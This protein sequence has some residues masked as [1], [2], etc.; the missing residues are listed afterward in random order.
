M[1]ISR[2]M[3]FVKLIFFYFM[4]M[5]QALTQINFE[6]HFLLD[7]DTCLNCMLYSKVER[8]IILF[9]PTA[10]IKELDFEKR[11]KEL[12]SSLKDIN[13]N[14]TLIQF[15]Y[16]KQNLKSDA[17]GL[18]YI[19]KSGDS[20]AINYFKCFIS[21]IDTNI[22]TRAKSKMPLNFEIKK[23]FRDNDLFEIHMRDTSV[24]ID[25]MNKLS[26]Y[27]EFIVESINPKYSDKERIEMLCKITNNLITRIEESEMKIEDL[28]AHIDKLNL[29]I[30]Q[31]FIETKE[32]KSSSVNSKKS[33]QSND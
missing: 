14:P 15:V 5:P 29:L 30:E 33:K 22:L 27:N 25:L 6:S 2:M 4:F 28:K 19:S 3:K 17:K 23:P 11:T 1:S 21:G 8:Q 24:C 9:Y 18:K 10:K 13:V 20:V 31:L 26:F 32:L 7:N 12:I 16:F